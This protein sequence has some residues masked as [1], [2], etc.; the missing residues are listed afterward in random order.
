MNLI[1]EIKKGSVIS[2]AESHCEKK[3]K[4]PIP[5]RYFVSPDFSYD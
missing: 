5:F 1:Q 4:L 2:H 3:G